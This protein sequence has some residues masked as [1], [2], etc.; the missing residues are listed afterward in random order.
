MR[1]VLWRLVQYKRTRI[2][3]NRP[4]KF[5]RHLPSLLLAVAVAAL[6][7]GVSLVLAG[8][9]TAGRAPTGGGHEWG[10]AQPVDTPP[11]FSAMAFGERYC[12]GYWNWRCLLGTSV[13]VSV[14]EAR[15]KVYLPLLLL[16]R[17]CSSVN[18]RLDLWPQPP[19]PIER[20]DDFWFGAMISYTS[21]CETVAHIV[22]FQLYPGETATSCE[23]SLILPD[24][25]FWM[26]Q[27]DYGPGDHVFRVDWRYHDLPGSDR[28]L[29]RVEVLNNRFEEPRQLFCTQE[30]YFVGP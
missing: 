6:A 11:V 16:S 22:A 2:G 8:T 23:D 19:G 30:I 5:V 15:S 1:T 3:E 12:G 10:T 29:M 26:D 20:R 13:P 25:P 27:E 4:V 9:A 18:P 7:L 24:R 21:E 17:P 28:L 14:T